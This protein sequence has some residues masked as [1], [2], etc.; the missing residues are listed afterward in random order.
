MAALCQVQ[1]YQREEFR[2]N[3]IG[4]RELLAVSDQGKSEKFIVVAT[5]KQKMGF[6][7]L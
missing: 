5:C 2:F 6:M 4:G 1:M 7:L 3:V